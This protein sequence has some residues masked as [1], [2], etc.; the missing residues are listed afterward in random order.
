[1]GHVCAVTKKCMRRLQVKGR[2]RETTPHVAYGLMDRDVSSLPKISVPG[3]E[4][5]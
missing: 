1:M 3:L 2:M 4:I 5:E